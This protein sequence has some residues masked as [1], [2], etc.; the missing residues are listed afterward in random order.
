MAEHDDAVALGDEM[1]DPVLDH[2]PVAHNAREVGAELVAAAVVA[3][4]GNTFQRLGDR[5]EADVRIAD[6]D[7][8]VGARAAGF[9]PAAIGFGEYGGV[10][11][12]VRHVVSP[13]G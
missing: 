13:R 2:L 5:A 9:R 8:V 3:H 7:P 6:R 11:G 4:V 1:V 10:A 12:F